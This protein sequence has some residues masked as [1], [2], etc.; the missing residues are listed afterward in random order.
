MEAGTATGAMSYV[1]FN[2]LT[3]YRFKFLTVFP[4]R[5]LVC[6]MGILLAMVGPAALAGLHYRS[7]CESTAELHAAPAWTEVNLEEQIQPKAAVIELA[8][9]GE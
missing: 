4:S 3:P 1:R 6:I 2:F 8:P 7:L 5:Y 9:D